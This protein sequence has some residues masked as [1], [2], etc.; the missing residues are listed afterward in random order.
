MTCLNT[1]GIWT[2]KFDS[3]FNFKEVHLLLLS[4]ISTSMFI[5]VKHNNRLL[6]SSMIATCFGRTDNHQ[7]VKHVI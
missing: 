1:V 3:V 5:A 7:A 6:N 2:V 4:D